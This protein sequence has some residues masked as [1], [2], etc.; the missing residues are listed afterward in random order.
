MPS[1]PSSRKPK[2]PR[3]K[4][5]FKQD[6]TPDRA[7]TTP[8]Y[9]ENTDHHKLYDTQ[10]WRKL[11]KRMLRENPVCPS[12]LASGRMEAATE[13]DHV[14]AHKGDRALFFDPSN[15][16]CLCKQCHAKK[17]AGERNGKAFKTKELWLEYLLKC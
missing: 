13:T 7:K 16:W 2:R 9:S 12:C 4:V 6:G 17:T 3:N 11:T 1:L 14:V 8:F 10:A 5:A 15:M